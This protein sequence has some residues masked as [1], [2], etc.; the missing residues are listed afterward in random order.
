MVGHLDAHRSPAVARVA[1][2]R[3][4]A[5]QHCV[6]GLALDVTEQQEVRSPAPSTV[7]DDAGVVGHRP[8]V[9]HA[10]PATRRPRRAP[11]TRGGRRRTARCDGHCRGAGPR[12]DLRPLVGRGRGTG[13]ARIWRTARPA[14]TPGS[15]ST[16]SAWKWRQDDGVDDLDPQPAQAGV[17]RRRGRARRRRRRRARAWWRA[18]ARRPGRRRR[19]RTASP[20]AARSRRGRQAARAASTQRRATATSRAAPGADGPSQ[21]PATTSAGS[22][23]AEQDRSRRTVRPG[24]RA[25]S[26][27]SAQVRATQAMPSVGQGRQPSPASR[28]PTGARRPTTAPPR[29]PSTVAGAT[30]GAASRFA[31]DPDHATPS[32]AAARRPAR[33]S[34]APPQGWRRPA[35]ASGSASAGAGDRWRRPS[36]RANSSRPRVASVDRAKPKERGQPRVDDQQRRPRP[37]TAPGCPARRRDGAQPEQPDRPHDGGAEDAGLGTG[38]DDEAGQQRRPRPPAASAVGCPSSPAQPERRGE[39]DGHVAARHRGQVGH[40]RR[41]HR[42]GQVVRR[43]AGVADDQAGQQPP[44]VRGQRGDRAAQAGTDAARRPPPPAR[45]RAAGWVAPGG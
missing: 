19:R 27:T 29:H 34:P 24:Q 23:T 44:G 32:P 2:S 15:P 45:R 13:L 33:T 4:R 39:D 10:G 42:L 22:A 6:C 1:G 37:R 11:A 35:P 28:A 25:A 12:V 40:A 9:N 41:E 5:E 30:S 43:A 38:E 21:R 3:R 7:E 31:S 17:D 26:G 8:V 20:A 16:W 36:G 14:S 18:P